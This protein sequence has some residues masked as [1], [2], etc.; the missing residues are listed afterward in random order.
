[1]E[2]GHYIITR[3]LKSDVESSIGTIAKNFDTRFLQ[4]YVD[5][6]F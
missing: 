4:K 6:N 3:K 2:P 5:E 1:M